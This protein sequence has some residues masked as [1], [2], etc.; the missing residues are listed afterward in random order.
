MDTSKFI[1]AV[2][3]A[4]LPFVYGGSKLNDEKCQKVLKKTGGEGAVLGVIVANALIGLEG[5][6][7]TEKGIWFS[8][9]SGV[10][11]GMNIPKRKGAF[12][13][14]SFVLNSVTVKKGLLP[15]FDVEF[16]MIDLKKEKS[17]T[18]KF[19]LVEEG[20]NFEETM[21]NELEELF[22]TFVSETNTENTESTDETSSPVTEQ[23]TNTQ[24][25]QKISAGLKGEGIVVYKDWKMIIFASIAII[26]APIFGIYSGLH[27][28]NFGSG[29]HILW[30]VLCCVFSF[31]FFFYQK[32]LRGGI[33]IDLN[34][35]L[36]SFPKVDLLAFFRP[37]PR[38][39]ISFDEITGIE[40]INKANVQGNTSAT[41]KVIMTYKFVIHGTFGSKTVSFRSREKRDQFYSL[42][43][44]YGNFPNNIKECL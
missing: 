26:A 6:V 33:I 8:L 20:L 12:P 15:K 3:K 22:N 27:D 30:L 42:L 25:G 31:I 16:V 40:A 44:T 37:Y 24:A 14:D 2:E 9:S 18:F 4:R 19:G 43:A 39:D 32:Y 29:N 28:G 5:L 11:G 35:R 17:F 7:V 38:N 13:F 23:N 36:I 1:E 41:L 10:T 21:S 34:S